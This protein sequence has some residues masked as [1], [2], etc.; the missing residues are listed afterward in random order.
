MVNKRKG[1]K[2]G[3]KPLP[4]AIKRSRMIGVA[5]NAAELA[6]L[7]RAAGLMPVAVWVRDIAIAAAKGK[8]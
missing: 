5:V 4:K 7:R 1:L 3:P 6:M 8:R 2:T